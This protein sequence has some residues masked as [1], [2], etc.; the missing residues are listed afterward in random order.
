M[1]ML[2]MTSVVGGYDLC[3]QVEKNSLSTAYGIGASANKSS[4]FYCLIFLLNAL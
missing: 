1:V 2:G 4:I 3:S